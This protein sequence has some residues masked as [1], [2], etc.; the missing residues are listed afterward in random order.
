MIERKSWQEFRTI[1]LLWWVNRA[2][3]LFGWAICYQI[4]ADGSLTDVYPARVKFRGFAEKHEEEGFK[5]LSA[6]LEREMPLIAKQA[7]E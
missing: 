7:K 3:H 5:T 6:Y 2:L 4:E 1:G